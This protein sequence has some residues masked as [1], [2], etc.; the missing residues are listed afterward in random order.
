[1]S[2]AVPPDGDIAAVVLAA[3]ASR[4]FGAA[5]KLLAELGGRTL[6]ER[7]VEAVSTAGVTDVVVV[8]GWDSAAVE[9][10][11][12]GQHVRLV[13][14]VRWEE[15]MGAS[16]AAGI[17]AVEPTAS[18]AFII[19][20]DLP[21]LT[22]HAIA[23]LIAAF[24]AAD[25][26][27]IVFPTTAAG[28]QRNPVLWPRAHFGALLSLPPEKGAKALL[29]LI[30]DQCLSVPVDDALLSDVDTSADLAALRAEGQ[31]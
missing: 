2:L 15:G 12:R 23:S 7:V 30:A 19:P 8:T 22:P 16:I 27:R 1:V 20:A 21:L 6:L 26:N 31:S 13:H 11:L 29:Q 10:A 24:R 9:T 18:G 25:C 5:N 28:E 4:R 3:G 17:A 14:N